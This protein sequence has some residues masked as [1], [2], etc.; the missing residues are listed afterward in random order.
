MVRQPKLALLVSAL[1]RKPV[2]GRFS[3]HSSENRPIPYVC[4]IID[5][6]QVSGISLLLK[7]ARFYSAI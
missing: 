1:R 2:H 6:V 3:P 5:F 7:I 4:K